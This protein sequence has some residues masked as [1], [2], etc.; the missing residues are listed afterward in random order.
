MVRPHQGSLTPKFTLGPLKI[1][2]IC[3]IFGL[4]DHFAHFSL[5]FLGF[6]LCFLGFCLK[7]VGFWGLDLG[8]TPPFWE[9]IWPILARTMSD[10][11]K[12]ND[13][14]PFSPIADPAPQIALC[15][16]PSGCFRPFQ[17]TSF[18]TLLP[19]VLIASHHKWLKPDKI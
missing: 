1:V 2:P 12:K 13:P 14:P 18:R 7:L 5:C 9:V 11:A 15:S 4:N 3:Q 10:L 19:R 6:S 17:Y 8:Q 16:T